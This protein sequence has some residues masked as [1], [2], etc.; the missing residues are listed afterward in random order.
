MFRH[1]QLS[2]VVSEPNMT[3][4]KSPRCHLPP[5]PSSVVSVSVRSERQGGKGA[6]ENLPEVMQTGGIE[7]LR[8]DERKDFEIN[9][10]SLMKILNA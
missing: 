5:I 3:E 8:S 10:P 9:Q 4:N 1:R 6:V 7:K 2:A